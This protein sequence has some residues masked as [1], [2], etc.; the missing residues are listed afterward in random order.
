MYVCVC[1]SLAYSL[2]LVSFIVRIA[3]ISLIIEKMYFDSGSSQSDPCPFPYHKCDSGVCILEKW[4]CNGAEEC[5]DGS[6]EVNCTNG[7]Y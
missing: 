5:P 6:D 2:Y 1:V 7:E 3:L 4:L